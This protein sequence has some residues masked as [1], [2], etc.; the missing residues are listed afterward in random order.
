MPSVEL[1]FLRFGYS[2]PSWCLPIFP[3]FPFL[4]TLLPVFCQGFGSECSVGGSSHVGGIRSCSSFFFTDAFFYLSWLWLPFLLAL[5]C[6]LLLCTSALLSLFVVLLPGV[7]LRLSSVG[8]W[9]PPLPCAALYFSLSFGFVVYASPFSFRSLGALLPLLNL[10]S[11]RDGVCPLGRVSSLLGFLHSFSFIVPRMPFGALGLVVFCFSP[12]RSLVFVP[13]FRWVFSSWGSVLLLFWGFSRLRFGLCAFF[14]LLWFSLAVFRVGPSP[15]LSLFSLFFQGFFAVVVLFWSPFTFLPVSLLSLPWKVPISLASVLFRM[16]FWVPVW[17]LRSFPH[18]F[19]CFRCLACVLI[20]RYFLSS[21]GFGLLYVLLRLLCDSVESKFLR[22]GILPL[23]RV[24]SVGCG[25][26]VCAV[27]ICLSFILF[28]GWLL[29]LWFQALLGLLMAVPGFLPSS[30]AFLCRPHSHPFLRHFPVLRLS[31]YRLSSD[32]PA[33]SVS[34]QRCLD[35]LPNS[36]SLPLEPTI[37]PCGHAIGLGVLGL[38]TVARPSVPRV[39]SFL[40]SLLRSLRSSMVVFSR[41][42]FLR[43][44]H[45]LLGPLALLGHSR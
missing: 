20:G 9:A 39:S 33:P 32:P 30:L 38:D 7:F 11:L 13:L 4:S 21:F 2:S 15:A 22:D 6:I 8:L 14:V 41:A 31:G 18:R 19:L 37:G 17:L 45:L 16:S 24:C 27:F 40:L 25:F 3:M 10:R 43:D 36:G 23:G 29:R 5:R 42:F 28:L 44:P 34:L 35:T 1:C 26:S 12:F